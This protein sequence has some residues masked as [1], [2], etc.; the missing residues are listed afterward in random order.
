MKDSDY[1]DK[2]S[3][4]KENFQS[5]KKL[6][7]N[8]SEEEKFER[9]NAKNFKQKIRDMQAEERWEDWENEIY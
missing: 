5:K 2:K 4:R 9:K 1:T 3:L 6:R 7:N 8:F